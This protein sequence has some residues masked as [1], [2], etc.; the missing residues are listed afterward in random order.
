MKK[1][2]DVVQFND[3]KLKNRFFRSGTWIC[4]ANEDG[5]LKQEFF[6][7]YKNLADANLGFVTL[8]YARVCEEEKANAGMTGL[9]DDKFIDDLKKVTDE[10]H[11]NQTYVGIQLAMGGPQ[12][13]YFGDITWKIL[14]PSAVDLHPRKDKYGNKVVYK[15]N[16]ITVEEI[17]EVI[18]K[19]AKA[20]LRVKKAGFDM[21]QL[22]CG[23]GYFLSSWMNENINTRNDM[24]G[25]SIENRSRFLIELY[26]EVRKT[27]GKDFKIGVKVNSEEEVG[28]HSN[29][30]A[31]LYLCKELDKR[32][33]DLIEVSGNFPSRMKIDINNES[34]F[35][36]FAKKLKNQVN[37]LIVL[38]GGNK[39]FSN[40][41]SV[42]NETNIDLIGLSR[43]LIAEID[44]V[45]TWEENKNHISKCV[46]CNH[47]H[48]VINTCVFNKTK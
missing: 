18:Q 12:V 17:K 42:L 37:A 10:F 36:D 45:K 34:Y 26:E 5:T 4:E 20:A 39:T 31:M 41:E 40:I 46:S 28:D 7:Y 23:H 21:V 3:L 2:F 9:W 47:C 13:H 22:H 14:A 27:V 6:D 48:K 38:T 32:N 24:Y 11:K 33:I 30:E 8:G 16:E 44:L 43:P 1:L 25:G 35:K 29:H 15:A 19:F